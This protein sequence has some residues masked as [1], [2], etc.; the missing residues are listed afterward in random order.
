MTKNLNNF[1]VIES[2]Y[3]K[4]VVNRHSVGHA[5]SLIKTGRSHMQDELD[6]ILAIVN[7]LPA[8][9]T[10]VDAGANIGLVSIP[11]AHAIS[12][13]GGVV[14]A[15]EVQRM[16]YYTL[17]GS[18]ALNDLENLFVN[19]IALGSAVG[20]MNASKLDYGTPQDFGMFSLID[21]DST[22]PYEKV[23]VTTI[24]HL[25]LSGLDFFKIDVEGMEIEVLGGALNS[26]R[27]YTPWCW[28]E[29]WK[30]DIAAI[31]QKFDGLDY[32]FFIMDPLNM[33]CAPQKRLA[34]S[35]LTV[36]AQEA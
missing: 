16:L 9:C 4:F 36:N 24:D 30:V 11:I 32:K 21:Q 6:N 12:D 8:H 29:Y 7:I 1:T 27:K 15:F 22:R 18:V 31:K 17:C 5:E 23:A 25:A 20:T 19:N 33:L 34:A 3:G 10:V 14:H 35:A 2:V 26:I 28:V 13:R